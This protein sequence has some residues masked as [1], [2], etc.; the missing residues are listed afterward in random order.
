L[1]D[2]YLVGE[3]VTIE[4]TPETEPEQ[5][6]ATVQRVEAEDATHATLASASDG[7]HRLTLPALSEGVYRV[8]VRGSQPE[9]AVTDI[10]AVVEEGRDAFS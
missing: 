1:E 7:V 3:P 10:F 2:A 5:L 6:E 9:S 8:T 4:A